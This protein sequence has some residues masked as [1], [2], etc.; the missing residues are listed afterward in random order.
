MGRLTNAKQRGRFPYFSYLHDPNRPK[1]DAIVLVPF[2]SLVVASFDFPF[3]GVAQIRDAMRLRVKQIVGESLSKILLVPLAVQTKGKRSK[4]AVFFLHEAE[5]I[6]LDESSKDVKHVFWPLPLAFS[7][8]VEGSGLVIYE[9]EE[10]LCSMW[11]DEWVPQ[12]YRYTQRY[13]DDIQQEKALFEEHAS[14]IGKEISHIAVVD[15]TVDVQGIAE[16]TLTMCPA[17]EVLDLS[18]RGANTAEQRERLF[19]HLMLLTRRATIAAAVVCLLMAGVFAQRTFGGFDFSQLPSTVYAASFG[20]KSNTPLKS[21][22]QKVANVSREEKLQ[23]LPSLMKV[24]LEP[25]K[26]TAP[27]VLRLDSLRYNEERTELQG[28]AKNSA[29]IQKL[30]EAISSRGFSA[31]TG[32]IQQIPGGGFRFTLT[33]QGDD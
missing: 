10:A 14:A 16:K 26:D 2:R 27:G 1:G 19:S 13:E 8:T 17:F 29:E 12:L 11:I 25:L 21:A 22:R 18:P 30:R 15:A 6:A 4:G 31:K 32:D 24:V 33:I 20:E 7:S 3:S 5:C 23:T 9:S 28:T